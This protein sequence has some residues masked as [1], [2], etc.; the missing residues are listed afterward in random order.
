MKQP[1]V[2][3]KNQRNKS[4]IFVEKKKEV[5]IE[6]T[7]LHKPWDTIKDLIITFQLKGGVIACGRVVEVLSGNDGFIELTEA[8]FKGTQYE[9]SVERAWI[10]KVVVSHMHVEPT[11]IDDLLKK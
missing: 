5:T 9:V 1:V 8:T 2:E 3:Y 6:G 11:E 10:R 7:A 4:P